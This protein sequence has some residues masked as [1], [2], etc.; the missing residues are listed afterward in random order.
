[1]NENLTKAMRKNLVTTSLVVFISLFFAGTV[2]AEKTI[3]LKC[4]LSETAKERHKRTDEYKEIY[5]KLT[6]DGVVKGLREYSALFA[7]TSV[8]ELTLDSIV[9][10]K[11]IDDLSQIGRLAIGTQYEWEPS[12]LT[13]T[14]YLGTRM[15]SFF[16]D[17][18]TLSYR[19]M[20]VD[21]GNKTAD[22]AMYSGLCE[23]IEPTK[24]ML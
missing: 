14:T 15:T 18:G 2:S 9:V 11:D 4:K 21:L 10:D 1:M 17:R 7:F 6:P 13:V 20:V 24:K 3:S 5:A 19:A 12:K 23:I 8:R 22:T 16:I